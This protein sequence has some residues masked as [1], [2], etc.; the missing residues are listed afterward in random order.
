MLV[1]MTTQPLGATYDR[2]YSNVCIDPETG[3]L[4][5]V[6]LRIGHDAGKPTILL[7]TCE[8]ECRQQP[9]SDIAINGN[10]ITFS[11]ADQIFNESH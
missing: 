2:T 1:A 7:K 3:D 6:E 4:G 11:A 9:T 8:G 10:R 5:G